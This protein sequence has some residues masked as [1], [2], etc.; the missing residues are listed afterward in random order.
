MLQTEVI[1]ASGL[2][3]DLHERHCEVDRYLGDP[4]IYV[5][6]LAAPTCLSSDIKAVDEC[7]VNFPDDHAGGRS[8][9]LVALYETAVDLGQMPTLAAFVLQEDTDFEASH[10]IARG[11][12]TFGTRGVVVAVCVG[13]IGARSRQ[14]VVERHQCP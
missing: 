5:H 10:I 3:E 11:L 4:V 7:V 14:F 12:A 9:F 13:G 6:P 1:P 8:G 2:L